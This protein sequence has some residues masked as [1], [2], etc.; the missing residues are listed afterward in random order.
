MT[1]TITSI[2]FIVF[3][4][5][6]VQSYRLRP[7]SC[8]ISSRSALSMSSQ[9]VV[10]GG[11]GGVAETIASKLADSGASVSVVLN[12]SPLSPVL[13]SQA[14]R[15][16]LFVGD[17]DKKTATRVSAS[18]TVSLS[19]LL[20]GKDVVVADDDGDET[21]PGVVKAQEGNGEGDK[22]MNKALNVFSKSIKSVT[23]ASKVSTDDNNKIGVLFK[24]KTSSAYRS[25]CEQNGVPFSAFQYGQLTGGIIG[26]EPTPFLGM[27]LLEPEVHPSYALRAVVM[28]DPKL[29]KYAASELCTRDSLSEA[30]VKS[31]DPE[32]A[33]SKQ[34]QSTPVEALVVS[35]VGKPTSP[36]GWKQLFAR[37]QNAN[38]LE[39]LRVSFQQILKPQ[40]LLNWISDSWF[41]QALIE[42]DA[43]TILSGARPVKAVN[44]ARNAASGSAPGTIKILWEDLKPDLTVASV[45][46]LEIS[47]ELPAGSDDSR[48][49]ALV[50]KRVSGAALP[51]EAQLM[52]RLQEGINKN[53][54][55]KQ[56]CTPLNEINAGA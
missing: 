37:V 15:V 43:A 47:L 25:W 4:L 40:L 29:N 6:I 38:D 13:A 50:V 14:S 5:A 49:P 31:L 9:V 18:Q 45:G 39:V 54:Y 20:D 36:A 56:F 28:S 11:A 22:V 46:A 30:V 44:S 8:R 34:K 41:P 17:L 16:A 51:G 35:I 1:Y 2:Y 7:S 27:P 21:L 53:V 52:D 3:L 12:R 48:P 23:C 33:G 10:I 26:C 19:E 32:V 24:S 42:A 55:K